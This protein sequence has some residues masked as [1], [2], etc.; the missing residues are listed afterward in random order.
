MVEAQPAR[1]KKP[2]TYIPSAVDS[3]CAD[4]CAWINTASCNLSPFDQARYLQ[5]EEASSQSRQRFDRVKVTE[6]S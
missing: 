2:K 6:L 5:L 4:E 3:L 1:S